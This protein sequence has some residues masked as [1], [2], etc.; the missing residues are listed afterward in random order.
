M[1]TSY[2]TKWKMMR[3]MLN[4][5]PTTDTQGT[6]NPFQRLSEVALFQSNAFIKVFSHRTSLFKAPFDLSFSKAGDG[7]QAD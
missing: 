7:D 6:L 2:G 5:Q 3:V 1:L 4:Q